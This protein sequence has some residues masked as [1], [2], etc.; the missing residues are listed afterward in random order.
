[1]SIQDNIKKLINNE[2]SVENRLKNKRGLERF[3]EDFKTLM[4]LIKDYRAG[5]YKKIPLKTIAAA[6]AGVLYA[7]NPID[8]I[9]DSLPVIGAIDDVMVLGFC[10]KMMESDL[11]KYRNWKIQQTKHTA[12]TVTPNTQA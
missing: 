11:T 3:L 7:I 8:I 5:D 2:E 1:M 10:L 12:E 9:P 6:A 4:S